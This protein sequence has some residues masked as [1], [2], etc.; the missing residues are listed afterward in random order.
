MKRG[1]RGG[2]G[3]RGQKSG[4]YS[5]D[6]L[7]GP[8]PILNKSDNP[9]YVPSVG[10]CIAPGARKGRMSLAERMREERERVSTG[11]TKVIPKGIAGAFAGKKLPGRTAPDGQGKSKNALPKER[12]STLSLGHVPAP[13]PIVVEAP[14]PA[15]IVVKTLAPVSIVVETPAPVLALRPGG[16]LRPSGTLRPGGLR[17][18]GASPMQSSSVQQQTKGTTRK[19]FAKEKLLKFRDLEICRCRPH[20]L[21]DMTVSAQTNSLMVGGRESRGGR[22]GGNGGGRGG[23]LGRKK[24]SNQKRRQHKKLNNIL[25]QILELKKKDPACVNEAQMKKVAREVEVLQQLAIL[26]SN[27]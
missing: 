12:H 9:A 8:A 18:G 23:Q 19:I 5:E 21:Q 11:A 4:G 14:T 3:G 2:H 22:R 15:P 17:P 1:E 25:R 6:L 20:D 27:L 24:L 10:R 7:D 16:G 13:A 26:N